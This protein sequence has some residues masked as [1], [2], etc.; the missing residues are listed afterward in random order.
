MP[1]ATARVEMERY[2]PQSLLDLTRAVVRGQI[3]QRSVVLERHAYREQRIVAGTLQ[4]VGA[5]HRDA[6]ACYGLA[7]P[8]HA[9]L[10]TTHQARGAKHEGGFPRARRADEPDDF[11]SLDLHRHPAQ[12][13]NSHGAPVRTRTESLGKTVDNKC[14]SHRSPRENER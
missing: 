4:Y 8:A 6:A 14:G 12:R 7:E 5:T 1:D 10:F 11:P 2:C 9:S 3:V 13:V